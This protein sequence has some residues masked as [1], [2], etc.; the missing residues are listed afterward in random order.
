M[1]GLHYVYVNRLIY[2]GTSISGNSGLC[3]GQSYSAGNAITAPEFVFAKYT[4]V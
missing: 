2:L 4:S 3:Q 1:Q